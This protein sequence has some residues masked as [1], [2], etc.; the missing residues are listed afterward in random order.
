MTRRRKERG[1]DSDQRGERQIQVGRQ[2]KRED[3]YRGR[4]GG[5]DR[6]SR[7]ERFAIAVDR[8]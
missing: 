1:R 7:G 6:F 2:M 5:V 8:E 3:R 4:D